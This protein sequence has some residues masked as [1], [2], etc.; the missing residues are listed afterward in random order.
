MLK[1]KSSP[2]PGTQSAASPLA[3]QAKSSPLQNI[4]SGASPTVNTQGEF[5]QTLYP[6]F[7]QACGYQEW[8]VVDTAT[9]PR[10]GQIMRPQTERLFPASPKAPSPRPLLPSL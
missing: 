6:L 4:P 7:C 5:T 2:L 9:C 8:G 10:C 1:A 3:A